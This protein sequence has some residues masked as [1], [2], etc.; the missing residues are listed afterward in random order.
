MATDDDV[1]HDALHRWLKSLELPAL[2]VFVRELGMVLYERNV[3]RWRVLLDIA[4][5]LDDESLMAARRAAAESF[6]RLVSP[7]PFR[8]R[9]PR[10][11]T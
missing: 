5:E 2:A 10:T 6:S 4:A 9:R 1:D 3:R 11:G 8:P 7:A